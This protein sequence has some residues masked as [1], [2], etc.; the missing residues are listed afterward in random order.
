MFGSEWTPGVDKD[1]HLIILYADKLG[2]AI[3]L[4]FR[5]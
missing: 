3:R 4:F 1:E 5:N 2:G